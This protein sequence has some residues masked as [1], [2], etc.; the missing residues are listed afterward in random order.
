MRSLSLR[1]VISLIFLTAFSGISFSKE[2]FNPS[3]MQ[4]Q[5]ALSVKTSFSGVQR[6]EWSTPVDLW[7]RAHNANQEQARRIASDIIAKA[8]KDLGQSFCVH[9]HNG[10][11]KPLSD[12]CWSYSQ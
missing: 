2:G 11:W 6:A 1:I 8:K 9:V 3:E 4:S 7:V 12:M 10:D 5:F